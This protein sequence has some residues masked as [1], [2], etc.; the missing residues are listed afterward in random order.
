MPREKWDASCPNSH[1]SLLKSH[2]LSTTR[3]AFFAAFQA[4]FINLK[5]VEEKERVSVGARLSFPLGSGTALT[6]TFEGLLRWGTKAALP[7]SHHYD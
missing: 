3:A 4:P 1:F 2:F 7:P 6:M 5:R